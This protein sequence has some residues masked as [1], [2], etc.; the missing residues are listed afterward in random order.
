MMRVRK[1]ICIFL[2][3]FSLCINVFIQF[4][5]RFSLLFSSWWLWILGFTGG[6]RNNKKPAK[7]F[8]SCQVSFFRIHNSPE[9]RCSDDEDFTDSGPRVPAPQPAQ[10]HPGNIRDLQVLSEEGEQHWQ[11]LCRFRLVVHC[12]LSSPSYAVPEWQFVTDL[13]A[14]Y[15]VLL[16]SSI[17]FIIYC[18]AGNQFRSVLQSTF[19][20]EQSAIV[21]ERW[22]E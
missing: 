6:L 5:L 4:L 2:T 8:I 3:G 1:H 10:T 21:Q 12:V 7:H 14:R 16:N 20:S 11:S 9:K 15:L 22:L 18:L 17:N 19:T 13:A